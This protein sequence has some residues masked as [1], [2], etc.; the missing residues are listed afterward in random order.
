MRALACCDD[1]LGC[2]SGNGG[3]DEAAGPL[4]VGGARG[5]WRFREWKSS[6]LDVRSRRRQPLGGVGF[7]ASSDLERRLGACRNPF[8]AGRDR[9]LCS[10]L[11]AHEL[12]DAGISR[13]MASR[14][15]DANISG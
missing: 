14:P 9:G 13:Q 4:P 7:A 15:P 11:A 3:L 2:S 5:C 12:L 6:C 10:R 1:L 8:S